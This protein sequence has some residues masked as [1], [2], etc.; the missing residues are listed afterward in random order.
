MTAKPVADEGRVS[1]SS[2]DTVAGY[3]EDKLVVVAGVNPLN[4]L[5][6]STLNDGA[7]ED[8]QLQIDITKIDHDQLLNFVANEHIDWTVDQSPLQIDANNLPA[9]GLQ[10][11]NNAESLGI[12]STSNTAFQQKVSLALAG[13]DAG[14]YLIC[15][16]AEVRHQVPGDAIEC[17]IEQN[18]TTT[19]AL[20]RYY[21]GDSGGVNWLDDFDAFTGYRILNLSG[22]QTFDMDYRTVSGGFSGIIR[23]ASIVAWRIS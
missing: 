3:L 23:N 8:L 2:N 1:I 16:Y 9:A 21:S 14:S 4:I 13:L 5:E 12:S 15:F 20:Q 7:D 6:L 17:R 11:V 22:N 18:N 10:F 19:I